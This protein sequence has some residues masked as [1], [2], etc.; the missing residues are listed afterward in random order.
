MKNG[1]EIQRRLDAEKIT[2]QRFTYAFINASLEIEI[3][4]LAVGFRVLLLNSGQTSGAG[5]QSLLKANAAGLALNTDGR[6]NL[7]LFHDEIVWELSTPTTD[8]ERG[9]ATKKWN[10]LLRNVMKFRESWAKFFWFETNAH[11]DSLNLTL[12]QDG[13]PP[14]CRNHVWL[15]DGCSWPHQSC[16]LGL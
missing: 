5:I 1:K 4:K 7:A 10:Q 3:L 6:S 11:F 9:R 2:I 8:E 13:D 14:F 16:P 12:R 15:L